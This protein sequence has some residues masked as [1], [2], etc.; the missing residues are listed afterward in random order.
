MSTINKVNKLEVVKKM[1]NDL[2]NLII[3]LSKEIGIDSEIILIAVK[4]SVEA[5][6]VTE[7]ELVKVLYRLLV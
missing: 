1:S 6:R 7:E 2:T 5:G 4:E 3:K